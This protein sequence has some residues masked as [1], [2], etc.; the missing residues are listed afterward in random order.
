MRRGGT[1]RRA[2]TWRH[3]SARIGRGAGNGRRTVVPGHSLP[4]G[5]HDNTAC[6]RWGSS[7]GRWEPL[8]DEDHELRRVRAPQAVVV[9]DQPNAALG[10]GN[11]PLPAPTPALICRS[12]PSWPVGHHRLLV[13]GLALPAG[14]SG[15]SLPPDGPALA[16]TGHAVVYT[17]Q[18]GDTLWSIAQRGATDGRPAAACLPDRR[19]DRV[20]HG[21]ARPAHQLP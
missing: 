9:P 5:A 2:A 13:V 14:G 21:N 12:T 6:P 17:V 15:G 7:R 19:S 1:P 20:G 18:P 10:P 8:A 4:P 11:S 3:R 16:E